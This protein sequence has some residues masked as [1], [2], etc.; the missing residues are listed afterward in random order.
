MFA[1][2]VC[3]LPA[4]GGS[5]F[6]VV[7]GLFV[8][9]AGVV[10]ARWV[11]Q[12]AG[13]LSV[14]VA[15][16]VL[17]G[18][19]VLAPQTT[20]P[21]ASTTT[22]VAPATTTTVAPATTTTVAPAT[23]TTVAPVPLYS[24]G[25]PGPGGGTIFY[26]DMTRAVGSRYFEVACRGWQSDCDGTTA[27][28]TAQWGCFDSPISGAARTAIGGGKQN[29]EEIENLCAT[30]GIAAKLALAYSNNDLDD[31]FLPSLDELN[32][33]CKWAYVD[34]ENAVCNDS[35]NGG[36]T[37]TDLG[38]SLNFYWTST[39]VGSIAWSQYFY[40]GDQNDDF[41]NYEY[42]VRPIRSM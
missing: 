35:G 31:W 15:P 37:L 40:S 2:D 25:D 21:C 9:V 13:R 16:M 14:V 7:A 4:T 12:S 32:A 10:V 36:L 42:F 29:T 23:T 20:D 5:T 34:S 26:V 28:P 11:R 41:Y 30:A 38:F 18:G 1:V 33:L 39:R 8:L 17:L 6:V 24:V 3:D 27:D 22:T 19:L